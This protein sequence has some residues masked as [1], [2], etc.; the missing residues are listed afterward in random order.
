MVAIV[1]QHGH[2]LKL[3]LQHCTAVFFRFT[4]D[5]QHWLHFYNHR[6]LQDYRH[7]H[8]LKKKLVLKQPN[9]RCP[10]GLVAFLLLW[11]HYCFQTLQLWWD[12]IISSWPGASD[13]SNL[14]ISQVRGEWPD[15]GR[16]QPLVSGAA[17]SLFASLTLMSLTVLPLKRRSQSQTRANYWHADYSLLSFWKSNRLFNGVFVERYG[18]GD[19]LSIMI[20]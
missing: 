6:H 11:Q 14:L 12:Q 4:S 16:P 13:K 19:H 20:K 8:L 3:C 15:K 2:S 7:A 18:G 10:L 5:S 17:A 9:S 1:T